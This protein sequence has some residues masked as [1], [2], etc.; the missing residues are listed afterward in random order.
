MPG[1]RETATDLTDLVGPLWSADKTQ[2]AL[3]VSSRAAMRDLCDT[4]SLLGVPT[5]DG[6]V[7][8]P[9]AQ[10]ETHDG[11]FRVK[12]AVQQFMMALRERDP[13]TVA[14]L[15]HTPADELDECAPLDWVRRDGDTSTLLDYANLVAAAFSR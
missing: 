15:L 2:Q 14:V 10:F 1:T 5:A 8:Y 12:P 3:G 4:G 11:G 6:D 13:W 7:F 9:V